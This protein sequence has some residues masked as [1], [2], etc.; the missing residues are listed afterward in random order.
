[1]TGNQVFRTSVVHSAA[2]AIFEAIQAV[3]VPCVFYGDLAWHLICGSATSISWRL[4]VHVTGD[5]STIIYATQ[6]LASVDQRFSLVSPVANSKATMVY[7]H[8]VLNDGSPTKKH[9]C[10]VQ[11]VS[12]NLEDFFIVKDLPL[13][14][15]QSIIYRRMEPWISSSEKKRRKLISEV[16]ALSEAY[17]R[18]PNLPPSVWSLPTADRPVFL[19]HLAKIN[20]AFPETADLLAHLHPRLSPTPTISPT[21]PSVSPAVRLNST[22]I[23]D[24]SLLPV[25]KKKQFAHSETVLAAITTLSSCIRELGHDYFLTGPEH[26]PWYIMG[27]PTVPTNH[28][29]DFLIIL[30]GG[31]SLASL[32]HILRQQ[33]A[34]QLKDGAFQCSVLG[35]DGK[36]RPCK[37]TL[38]EVPS[39]M[40]LCTGEP[41]G[42]D[43]D[44][45]S[46]INQS[47]LFS[48]ML[49]S[50]S[51]RG[52]PMKSNTYQNVV[53]ALDL[54][55]LR[56]V[57]VCAAFEDVTE[58]DKLV[59]VCVD[60]HPGLRPYFANIGFRSALLPNLLT[61]QP[62]VDVH[63][64]CGPT[65][66][67]P[68]PGMRKK[69]G[70]V[71]QAAVDATRLLR[72]SG[73]L[74]AIFGSTACYLYGN[75][76]QPNDLNILVSSSG[77]AEEGK[78]GGRTF[79]VLYYQQYLRIGGGMVYKRTKVSIVTADTMMLLFLSSGS[80]VVKE[81]LPLVPLEVLLLHKL[82]GWHDHMTAMEPHK[83]GK[84]H[85]DVA[86]IRCTLKIVLQSLTGN[87]RSWARVALSFFQEEFQRPYDG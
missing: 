4:D 68:I 54:L 22:S 32:Q 40:G 83:Q 44:G 9:Q 1:M 23:V 84:Q 10:Q 28:R 12:S 15:I 69:A 52:L 62:E 63:T 64:V 24:V 51:S 59:R 86:D 11:F 61:L 21:P 30:R 81:S 33:G 75:K 39:S 45:I 79:Q 47:Y 72:D 78:R 2:V 19:D 27:S 46:I 67:V 65:P 41:M 20:A 18:L 73:H 14:P 29:L 87:E 7:I 36:S 8:D 53:A 60:A 74:C 43:F 77:N 80:T 76:R 70:L 71:L 16:I 85:V 6:H 31:D 57:D 82:Q 48:T 58:L 56:N 34:I 13:L 42:T 49:T 35:R 66:A 37:V 38:E 17:L 25:Q 3:N 50:V 26:V 55:C 5:S